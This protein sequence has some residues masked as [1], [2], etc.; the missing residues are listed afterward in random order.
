MYYDNTTIDTT[1]ITKNIEVI[2]Q[3]RKY[4]IP[5]FREYGNEFIDKIRS[6]NIKGMF[7]QDYG[8]N[9][10][11]DSKTIKPQLYFLFDVNGPIRYGQY[12]NIK[13]SRLSFMESLQWFRQKNYY[14]IDYPFDSNKD[15]HLHVVVF[16]L[17]KPETLP[18]FLKGQYSK[19]YTK[20][21]IEKW[22]PKQYIEINEGKEITKYT[23][24]YQVLTRNSEYFENFRNKVQ[25]EFGV[26]ESS[27]NPKA[28]YDFPP[29]FPNEILRYN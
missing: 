14:V 21:E 2:N 18:L 29:H 9:V 19:M 24:T 15:G 7:L 26:R 5:Q 13:H 16:K 25:E 28:E 11:D 10:T 20:D 12:E 4:L 23:T 17:P 27:V 1:N 8:V 3:T 22:I 6:L